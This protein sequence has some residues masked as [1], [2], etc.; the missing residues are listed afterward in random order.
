MGRW[1]AV[2]LLSFAASAA[3][4]DGARA[5]GVLEIA[6]K[7]Q[8]LVARITLPADQVVGFTH[9][10]GNDDE[11]MAVTDALARLG[12]ARNVVEP[13]PEAGCTVSRQ[14]A[15]TTLMPPAEP[16]P[17]V[18]RGRYT[19]RC[20]R[21]EA[22]VAVDLPL[23]EFVNGVPLDTLVV[24]PEGDYRRTLRAPQT[25]VPLVED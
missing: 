8:T 6:L 22:L 10:A 11:K 9:V 19:W 14:H 23:L 1:I 25:R 15:E 18:F 4:Q 13:V 12:E 16:P 24:G 7:G 2:L 17:A 5:T 21:P 20:E 3:A